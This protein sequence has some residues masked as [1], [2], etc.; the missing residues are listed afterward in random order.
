[1]SSVEI[2]TGIPVSSFEDL[3]HRL[4]LHRIIVIG[5]RR[6]SGMDFTV[7]IKD[8]LWHPPYILRRARAFRVEGLGQVT[9]EIIQFRV[10]QAM[11]DLRW[12]S[13]EEPEEID[14]AYEH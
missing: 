7:T 6:G 2:N 13:F 5:L 11:E 1:M 4:P 8:R 14:S 10:A 12:E 3:W 9:D